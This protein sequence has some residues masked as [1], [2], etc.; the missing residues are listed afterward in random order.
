MSALRKG[1]PAR[2]AS[3]ILRIERRGL[4]YRMVEILVQNHFV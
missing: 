2:Q 3:L 4:F 1:V